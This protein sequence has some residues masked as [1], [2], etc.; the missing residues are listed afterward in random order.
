MLTPSNRMA[1]LQVFVIVGLASLLVLSGLIVVLGPTSGAP[2][3]RASSV[4]PFTV[5]CTVTINH[6]VAQHNVVQR[7]IDAFGPL[8]TPSSPVAICLGPGTFPEQLTINDTT[9]LTLRGSGNGS[10]FLAPPSVGANGVDLDNPSSPA[11]AVVGAWNDSDLTISDLTVNGTAAG[12]SLVNNC[13]DFMGIYYGNT[14]G[15]L[16]DLSVLGIN[17]HGGCQGQ[18]AIYANNGFFSTDVSYPTAVS[19]TNSTV[20]GFGKNG[21]TCN[22]VGVTCTVA[23]NSVT[24]APQALGY[25]ATNG[26]QFWGAAGTITSNT[27]TGNDYLPGS[28]LDQNYFASAGSCASPYWSGGILVLSA[29]TVVNVSSNV[30]AGNQVGVWSIGA[31]TIAWDNTF[32]VSSVGYY[33]IVLDFS[34]VDAG[35]P[36]AVY[37]TGPYVGSAIGNQIGGQNVGILAYDDNATVDANTFSSVNVSVEVATDTGAAYSETVDQNTGSANVSGALLGDI[38]SFQTGD[39]AVPSGTYSVVGNSL[40]NVSVAPGPGRAYGAYIFGAAATVSGNDLSG[41]SEGLAVVLPS[42]GDLSA[43]GNT[44]SSPAVP[45]S[46][47]GLYAFAGNATLESNTVTGYSWMNG[48]GWWPNSQATGIFAQCLNSCAVEDNVVTDNAIGIAVLSYLYGPSPAPSWPNADPPSAGPLNVSGNFVNDSGAFGIA[49][50]LNQGTGAESATPSASVFGNAIDNTLSGAV[51]LM[52]DQGTYSILDNVF[53]GTSAGGS[54]GASQPTGVGTIDTASIQVLDAYDSV[55]NACLGFDQYLDTTLFVATLNLTTDPPYYASDCGSAPVTFSET[56][57]PTGTDWGVTVD[58][59]TYSTTTTS[60]SIDLPAGSQAFSVTPVAGYT[61]TPPS[62]SLT[63]AGTPLTQTIVFAVPMLSVTPSQGPAGATVTVSGTGFT[64]DTTL[65]SLEFDNVAIG[66]CTSGSLTTAPN[67][68]LGCTFAVPTG[69]SGTTVSATDSGGLVAS[70]SFTVTTPGITVTPGQGP[71]GAT[72]TVAGGG[73]S[74]LSPVALTFDGVAVS[75]CAIGSLS[76]DASGAFSCGFAVPSGTSGTTVTVTDAG[77]QAPTG[78][79]LVTTPQI[80]VGPGQ[81]PVGAAVTVSGTGFSVSQPVAL[82]FDGVTVA[83]CTSGSTTSDAAGAFSC[84]FSVPSGTS[85]TTVTA[86]DGGGQVSTG[87]F[88]VTTV[89]I[90]VTPGQGPVGAAVTVAGTGFSVST[91]VALSFGA[92]ALA[93]CSSGSLT[94]DA[95]GTFSCSFPVP[96]GTSGTTVTATDAGGTHASG[97]FTVTALSLTVSPK[98]GPIGAPVSVSGSGFSVSSSV[99]LTFDGVSVSS[100]TSGSL[101]TSASGTFSCGFSVMSGTSGT[102]VR[103]TDAGGSSATGVFTVTVPKITVSP[104]R[105]P[106]GARVTVTGTG[107]SVSSPVALVFDGVTISSCSGG[108][109][110]T[111]LATGSFSCSFRVPTGTSGTTVTGTDAYGQHASKPFTVTVPKIT[112]TPAHGPVGSSVTVSGTRY[113]VSST[114]ALVFDNVAITSCTTGSLTTSATGTF[115]C[116]FSVPSGTSGT[117]V[118][119]TDVGGQY[120]TK[121]F[122]V[123]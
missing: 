32:P 119:A 98:R 109:G 117:T 3:T 36:S 2:A 63:L 61:A 20:T 21:I 15:G 71:I 86:T 54:S 13:A 42:T 93:T 65:A 5:A 116:T 29:P 81:G 31:P 58:A 56:G 122:T 74:V 83:A 100:C 76:T 66:A 62:G 90:T 1:S 33:A 88:T 79:F 27:V 44:L 87:T 107:F 11:Y 53:V 69:T 73:F 38:S 46:G 35:G 60:I 26:I 37:T 80:T 51:G 111:T 25:A 30:L 10:T 6:E 4:S 120:A 89:L 101:A 17:D 23:N 103:A 28:C 115:S 91:P 104:T 48:P 78:T 18:N 75:S 68:A 99:T 34:L 8:S 50:E 95:S 49:F 43:T 110:L 72:V 114:V 77:G 41:F 47:G 96:S 92:V 52:V 67:G 64:G 22:D 85:G 59:S 94:S 45:V 19:I 16:A 121:S 97:T 84:G 57:L 12:N 9:S 24:T 118:T 7:A 123:T 106:V 105:G 39:T 112:V 40:T 113:S 108:G 14:S 82:T 102:T 70:A 55:T